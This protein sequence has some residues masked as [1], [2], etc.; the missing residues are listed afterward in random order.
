MMKEMATD[1][2][3]TPVNRNQNKRGESLRSV[4]R[5][6]FSLDTIQAGVCLSP[7]YL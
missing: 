7:A 4:T 6:L 1:A 3:P 5:T 2:M